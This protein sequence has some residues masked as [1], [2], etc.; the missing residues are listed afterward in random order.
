M[1]RANTGSRRGRDR[2]VRVAMEGER[3]FNTSLAAFARQEGV[4]DAVAWASQASGGSSRWFGGGAG[5]AY[6][7]TIIPPHASNAASRRH[8]GSP[9]LRHGYTVSWL[10]PASGENGERVY[11]TEAGAKRAAAALRA[12]N[13]RGVSVYVFASA[14]PRRH[15][16]APQAAARQRTHLAERA[17][18]EQRGALR[19]VH[20]ATEAAEIERAY[21]WGMLNAAERDAWLRAVG[22]G[23]SFPRW[24]VTH[25]RP[26]PNGR[27]RRGSRRR[28]RR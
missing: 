16:T 23:E 11:K 9:A 20:R 17:A 24:P 5:V 12:R 27:R 26:R 22:A 3:A 19:T 8:N 14:D 4:E 21:Q 2:R 7:V 28:A 25:Q 13:L 15:R 6:Q 1:S 10:D 18:M